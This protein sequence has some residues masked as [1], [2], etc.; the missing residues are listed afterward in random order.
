MAFELT[1]KSLRKI[2]LDN[3]LC[4]PRSHGFPRTLL[5][6]YTRCHFRG[7]SCGRYAA[8]ALCC[9][10]THVVLVATR[11]MRA[12]QHSS[13]C[14]L[15]GGPAFRGLFGADTAGGRGGGRD[16][17]AHCPE[18]NDVLHL[19]CKGITQIKSLE[20]R[21]ASALTPSKPSLQG[22]EPRTGRQ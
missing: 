12:L 11:V 18:L 13:A 19:Q 22:R 5:A 10:R 14:E 9:G 16:R 15:A 1:P 8:K 17:Y 21:R 6:T 20:V 4:V 2:C 3:K 7:S